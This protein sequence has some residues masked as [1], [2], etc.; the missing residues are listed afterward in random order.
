MFAEGIILPERLTFPPMVAVPVTD[1]NPAVFKLPPVT[2]PATDTSPADKIFPL[3]LNGL[4]T[5]TVPVPLA[6][7]VKLL[8]QYD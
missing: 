2:L 8:L 1:S 6:V 7:N 3:A 4:V 5:V